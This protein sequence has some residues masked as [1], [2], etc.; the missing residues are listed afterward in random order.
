MIKRET[1]LKQL[2]TFKDKQLIKVITGIRR[3]GKSTLLE[4]FTD[5]LK[6]SGVDE[7]HIIFINFEDLRY[8]SLLD[9]RKLYEYIDE[10]LEGSDRTYIFL[11][12][13][14]KV[15]DFQKA[16]DSLYIKKNT[17]IYIT[18]SNSDLLSSELST[19]LTGRYVEIKM[20]PL[21]F[22]EYCGY[23]NNKD[24]REC[25]R[26]YLE[27]GAMPYVI[28][29][30]E[31]ESINIYLEGICNT[32]LNNDVLKRYPQTDIVLLESILRFLAQNTGKFVSSNKIADTLTSYGRK[33]T[34]N[35]VEKYIRYLKEAFFI[36]ECKRFDLKGKQF[37]KSLSKYYFIDNGIRN[38]MLSSKSTDIGHVLENVVYLELMRRY[39]NVNVGKYKAKEVDFIIKGKNGYEYYQVAATLLDNKVKKREIEALKLIKDNYPKIILTFDD[40]GLG[41]EEGIKIKNII[42]FLLE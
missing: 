15:R 19:L 21:S 28:N 10:R 41:D 5:E 6:Q 8:E 14:Q 13:I 20:L 37:L 27:T 35:T 3:C 39:D 32:I 2:K 12:E 36:Y 18:G 40:I 7:N 38:M 33:T 31:E 26:R 1:Y 30:D 11:D 42:D 24:K 4:Q 29:F 34:Y 23:F 16:V 22:K 25:F 17:D 9:Y